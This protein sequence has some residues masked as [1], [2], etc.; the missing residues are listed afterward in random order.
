M[1]KQAIVI[2]SDLKLPKGKLAVQV[3]HASVENVLKLISLGKSSLVKEWQQEGMKKVVLKVD[4]LDTLLQKFNEAKAK[5]FTVSLI[6]D[7]GR[8]VLEEGTITCF[9]IGPDVE[10]KIDSITKGL[11]LV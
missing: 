3:A 8:T 7:A 5:G 1:Y 10:E 11:K 2:R 9:A 4:S 6:R